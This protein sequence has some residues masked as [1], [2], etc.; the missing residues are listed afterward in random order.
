MPSLSLQITPYGP[1]VDL[2]VGVSS[3][4]YEAMKKAGLPDPPL[5]KARMLVDTGASQTNVCTSIIQQLGISPT[6]QVMMHT[7]STGTTPVAMDQYDVNFYINLPH[8]SA[9]QNS[10]HVVP[11]IPVTSS[12]FSAQGI[13]GL[14]GR[15]I[16]ESATLVY[17]GHI[18]LFTLSF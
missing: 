8:A 2:M 7:P 4:R 14:I 5:I 16:L 12:N 11:T 9:L 17:H 10:M 1:V 3:P 13:D 6:G 15:D 18:K